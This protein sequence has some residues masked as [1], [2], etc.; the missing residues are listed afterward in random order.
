M[1]FEVSLGTAQLAAGQ[2]NAA[3]KNGSNVLKS[4]AMPTVNWRSRHFLG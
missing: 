2:V 1:I 3:D 4:C